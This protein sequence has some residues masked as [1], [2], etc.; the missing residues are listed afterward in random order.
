MKPVYSVRPFLLQEWRVYRDLRLRALADSP[1]AFSGTLVEG[2][3]RPD[4]EWSGRLAA[5]SDPRWNFPVVA[6]V[7]GE[8]IGLA[9]GRIEPSESDVAHLYQMWVDPKYRNLGV[10]QMLL[11]AVITWA[12]DANARYLD[13]CV[14]CGDSPAARLY[15]RAGFMPVG[16]PE[17]LRPGSSLLAQPM[18]L[19]L[20]SAVT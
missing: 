13:L 11:R 17:P 9:W 14:T 15:A 19:E 12:G 8:A 16:D 1:D 4:A 10:G 18:R 6:E 5:G 3:D 7:S 2:K 20:R